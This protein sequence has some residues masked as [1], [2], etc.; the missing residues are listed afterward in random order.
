MVPRTP[1][2]MADVFDIDGP[3]VAVFNIS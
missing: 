1:P 3:G 2:T